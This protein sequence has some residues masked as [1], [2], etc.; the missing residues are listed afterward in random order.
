MATRKATRKKSTGR[1]SSARKTTAR[2]T[3]A[4]KTTARKTT[5]RKTTARKPT[6]RKT[7]ARK[8][9]GEKGTIPKIARGVEKAAKTPAGRTA[10]AAVKDI[11]SA[12]IDAVAQSAK[13]KIGGRG[14]RSDQPKAQTE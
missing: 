4:R 5:A 13:A 3:T 10:M 7:S 9:S 2:K 14:R 11:A 6:A 1:K 8:T 12:A